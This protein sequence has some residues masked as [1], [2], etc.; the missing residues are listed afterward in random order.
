[1]L[2]IDSD[3]GRRTVLVTGAGGFIGGRVVEVLEA[4]GIA[5]PR[6]GVRR[7]ATAARVGRLPVEIVQCDV[8]DADQVRASMRGVA[9]VIHCAMGPGA[10]NVA[11]TRNVLDAAAAEQVERV[12]HLSTIE[13]YGDAHGEIDETTPLQRTGSEYGDSKIAAEDACRS[14]LAGGLP[15]TILRP[16]IVYGPFS[17]HF[18]IA[19]A[20][21]LR[22]R[23]WPF[24]AARAGGICNLVYV[25]DVVGAIL[26]ALDAPA[27]VGEA[28]NVN[29][30]ERPT[31]HEYFG[32]LNDALG[33]PPLEAA[34][35][36]SSSL[37]TG[38]LRP[39]RLV[40][41]VAAKRARRP[42]AALG[43]RS[44]LVRSVLRSAERSLRS[45]PTDG[46][47][48]LY[49]RDA[50]FSTQKAERVLGYR[51]QFSMA[52]GVRLSADWLSHHEYAPA[53]P[54]PVSISRAGGGQT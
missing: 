30:P 24:P 44:P 38:A 14:A 29:G 42:L 23:P 33:L 52:E 35:E 32:A 12:V 5:R 11:G 6:A 1:M 15:V 7:W 40:A 46:E 18:T 37:R 45:A 28:F 21:R 34:G 19:Y 54:I 50:S 53:P 10:V 17:T 13:V 20:A 8:N 2:V 39:A 36:L 3:R 9:A 26:C 43:R 4:S 25:D 22:R 16:S 51:A 49:G 31:W 41:G 47:F 27:A 48:R